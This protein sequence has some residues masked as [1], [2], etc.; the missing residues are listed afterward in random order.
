M[1]ILQE[2]GSNFLD[3]RGRTSR[4]YLGL[5]ICEDFSRPASIAFLLLRFGFRC[6]M[7]GMAY[8]LVNICCRQMGILHSKEQKYR[9][10]QSCV[11]SS[12]S[13]KLVDLRM[14][15]CWGIYF[16]RQANRIQVDISKMHFY[17]GFAKMPFTILD[18][19]HFLAPAKQECARIC[20]T[21]ILLY[22]FVSIYLFAPL[23]Q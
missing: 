23:F 6:Y 1:P 21:N 8:W 14:E 13:Q 5:I 4:A 11:F 20:G 18:L 10:I 2:L 15:K 16:I 12:T 3:Q 7:W 17:V 19:M 22:F 9:I